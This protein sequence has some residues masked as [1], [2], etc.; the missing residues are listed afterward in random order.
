MDPEKVQAILNWP[1]PMNSYE[2]IIFHGLAS[3]YRKFIKNFSQ[4]CAPIID[5]FG[6]SRWPFKWAESSHRNFKLLK[7]K[8]TEN[9]IM[10]LPSYDKVFQVETNG[11]GKTIGVVLSQKQRP[12]AYLSE[13]LKEEKQKYSTY[14][15]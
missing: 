15:K 11:S 14:D 7:K 9:P 4:I 6:G 10:A 3:F 2:L 13:K 12:V 5:I 8:I 1:T